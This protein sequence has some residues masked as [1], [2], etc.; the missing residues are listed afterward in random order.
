MVVASRARFDWANVFLFR[1]VSSHVAISVGQRCF[2]VGEFFFVFLFL[3]LF[4]D[5]WTDKSSTA[6]QDP[7]VLETEGATE[8]YH[9]FTHFANGTSGVNW[10]R[11]GHCLPV[12]SVAFHAHD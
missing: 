3:A 11:G 9:S 4:I 2:D 10:V 12:W 5:L 8:E 6:F 1:P 7:I